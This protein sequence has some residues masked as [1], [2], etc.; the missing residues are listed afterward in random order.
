MKSPSRERAYE[1]VTW[2]ETWGSDEDAELVRALADERD[3]LRRELHEEARVSGMG[4]SREARLI[5]ER[6]ELL[7]ENSRFAAYQCNTPGNDEYGNFYCRE[8][9][10]LRRQIEWARRALVRQKRVQPTDREGAPVTQSGLNRIMAHVD[11][12]LA[13]HKRLQNALEEARK[14]SARLDW[15]ENQSSRY[16]GWIARESSTGRG[17]RLHETSRREASDTA[18]AAI[19]AAMEAGDE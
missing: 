11:E 14:D 6:D 1:L 4:G 12:L 18:R 7:K 3:E 17:Y 16:G 5:A 13:E 19:D 15:L 9:K 2:I 8:V 10:D